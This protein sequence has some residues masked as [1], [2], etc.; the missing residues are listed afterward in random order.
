MLGEEL[1]PFASVGLCFAFSGSLEAC[2]RLWHLGQAG[3]LRHFGT[4]IKRPG[5]RVMNGDSLWLGALSCDTV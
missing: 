1:C 3:H 5:R 2:A 4:G